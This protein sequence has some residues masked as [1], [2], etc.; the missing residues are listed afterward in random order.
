MCL[1]PTVEAGQQERNRLLLAGN[2]RTYRGLLFVRRNACGEKRR[3][4]G[5]RAPAGQRS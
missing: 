2:T 3:A 1:N 4:Q 5:T